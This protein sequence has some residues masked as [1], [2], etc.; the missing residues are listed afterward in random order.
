MMHFSWLKKIRYVA[1]LV[2][3]ACDVELHDAT[4]GARSETAP[5]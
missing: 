5:R 1:A 2:Q 3:T 4:A